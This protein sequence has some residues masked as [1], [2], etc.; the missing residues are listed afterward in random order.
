[1]T[2]RRLDENTVLA[3]LSP[4][5]ENTWNEFRRQVEWAESFA[6][7]FLFSASRGPVEIFRERLDSHLRARVSRLW[8]LPPLEPVSCVDTVMEL[9]RRPPEELLMLKAT[10]WLDLSGRGDAWDRARTALLTR[11]NEHRELLR[12][13]LHQPVVLIFPGGWRAQVRDLAPD[14][15]AVRAYSLD[16][17][18]TGAV[19]LQGASEL[20][21]DSKDT[22][23]S[24]FP[25]E[26]L[27]AAEAQLREWQRLRETAAI[28]RNLLITG[29]RA[30]DAAMALKNV[31]FSE[32]IAKETLDI[33][34]LLRERLGDLP[35]PLRDT[36]VSLD[37]VGQASRD[38]GHL[39]EAR[40]AFRKS[41][42]LRLQLRTQLGDLPEILRDISVSLDNVGQVSRDL[43]Q[44]KEAQD[45]FRESL[46]LRRQ[47]RTQLG[48]LPEILRDISVSLDNVG[49]VSRDLGQLE[50]ARDA[51]RESLG[52]RRQLRTQVG[53]TP[54]T[55]RDL[56]I[57]LDN[58]AGASRAL[59]LWENARDALWESLDLAR[60]IRT[61]LG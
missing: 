37:K 52:L 58:V 13:Q 42:D 3:G 60:Q 24:H 7:I 8:R 6:L 31:H 53:D 47:L 2:A 5:G 48:D 25:A 12:R 44:L 51:F 39:E 38:L 15:W 36:S 57:A 21:N 9:V 35:Q 26:Q 41:L 17:D 10:L 61:Q 43:G 19:K 49:Q 1:M 55:L 11:L 20:S 4:A 33:A 14:L 50:V 28:D 23:P 45:A 18:E 16:L 46:G 29:W 56:S 32:Q 54:Q 22:I 34:H 27:R 40:V 30:F 59:G